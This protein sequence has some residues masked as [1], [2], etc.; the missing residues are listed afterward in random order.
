MT[1]TDQRGAWVVFYGDL[2]AIWVY[3]EEIDALRKAV[4]A[5][6]RVVWLPEGVDLTEVWC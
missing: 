2:S 6:A 3:A 5:S 1:D 4:E